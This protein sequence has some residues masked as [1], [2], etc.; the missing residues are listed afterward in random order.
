MAEDE[1]KEFDITEIKVT[2]EYLKEKLYEINRYY[3]IQI[4][5]RYMDMIRRDL[6]GR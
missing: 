5:Q 6:T 1:K 3:W 2:E 4:W